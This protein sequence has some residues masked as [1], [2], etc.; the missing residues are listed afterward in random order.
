MAPWCRPG[1]I[2]TEIQLTA[3]QSFDDK[4]NAGASGTVQFRYLWRIDR[5]NHFEKSAAM[6]ERGTASAVGEEAEVADADQTLSSLWCKSR[7]LP[8]RMER[9]PQE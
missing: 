9:Y 5:W 1:E 3:G 6:L 8:E 4:H 7:Y 2:G